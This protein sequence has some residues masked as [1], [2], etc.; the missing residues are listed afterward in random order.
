MVCIKSMQA[1]E[2]FVVDGGTRLDFNSMQLSA[3]RN[4]QVHFIAIGIAVKIELTVFCLVK[5]IF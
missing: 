5:A 1:L 2:I 4:K 3:H